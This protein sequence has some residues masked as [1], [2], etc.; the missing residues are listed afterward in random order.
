MVAIVIAAAGDVYIII[1]IG[2]CSECHTDSLTYSC[3]V[4]VTVAVLSFSQLSQT[5]VTTH[6]S[7]VINLL[8]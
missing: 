7:N 5:A 2:Q 4:S 1:F 6:H 8:Q 3:C